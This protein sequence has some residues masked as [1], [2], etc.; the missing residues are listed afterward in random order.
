MPDIQSE[1]NFDKDFN[2]THKQRK[3]VLALSQNQVTLMN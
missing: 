2:L 3:K 1:D